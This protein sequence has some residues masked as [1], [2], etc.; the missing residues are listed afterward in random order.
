MHDFDGP[1]RA[2]NRYRLPEALPGWV[3]AQIESERASCG[4][5]PALPGLRSA[6]RV[7]NH[8]IALQPL[9]EPPTNAQA[10]HNVGLLRRPHPPSGSLGAVAV[11]RA[12]LP[13]VCPE[14]PQPRVALLRVGPRTS[15]LFRP[16]KKPYLENLT[17]EPRRNSST[18]TSQATSALDQNLRQDTTAERGFWGRTGVVGA[19]ESPMGRSRGF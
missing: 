11:Y 7:G 16:A 10:D 5:L 2:A 12:S 15:R 14:F 1:H 19:E 9:L 6:G 4:A 8:P 13:T 3:I 17:E 18:Q